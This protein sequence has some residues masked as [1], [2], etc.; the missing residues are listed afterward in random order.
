M[1][2]QDCES[3]FF[4]NQFSLALGIKSFEGLP[5]RKNFKNFVLVSVCLVRHQ[6]FLR[7]RQDID[8]IGFRLSSLF[9]A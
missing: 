1:I 2:A 9:T 6:R 7:H 8:S 5:P 4:Q 3:N